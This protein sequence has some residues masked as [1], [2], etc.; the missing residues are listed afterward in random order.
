MLKQV[1]HYLVLKKQCAILGRHK[2]HDNK[3]GCDT[4]DAV[5]LLIEEYS[6]YNDYKHCCIN[7]HMGWQIECNFKK[8]LT[9]YT[10]FAKMM[11]TDALLYT[12]LDVRLSVWGVPVYYCFESV[13][14]VY[15]LVR[16]LKKI[17][18]LGGIIRW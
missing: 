18:K 16:C 14:L 4:T 12:F 11:L 3:M 8:N 15:R 7:L 17:T 6:L 13:V 5:V 9:N 1:H 2:K 10:P